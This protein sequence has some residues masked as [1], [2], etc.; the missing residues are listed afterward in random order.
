ML[1]EDQRIALTALREAL[2]LCQAQQ[3]EMDLPDGSLDIHVPGFKTVSEGVYL[4]PSDLD[5]LDENTPNE[6]APS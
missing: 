2:I 3:I 1:T 6:K 4:R 5:F